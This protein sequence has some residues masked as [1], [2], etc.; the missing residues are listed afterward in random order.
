MGYNALTK[1]REK[2]FQMYGVKDSV[3]IPPL[4]KV[5]RAYGRDALAFVRDCCEDLLFDTGDE[6]RVALDDSDGR[7]AGP[8]RI[9]YNMERDIDRLCLEV[10]I[11]RFL[12]TGA[13]MDAFDIYYCYCEIFK[14]FGR[15]YDTTG[16]LLELLSEHET[17][18]SSLLMKHRDH[19]SHSVYVFLIGLAFYKNSAVI[20]KAYN[21]RY[22]LQ[23]GPEAARH[24]LKYWGMTALFHDIGYPF[25]IA[26]QQMKAYVCKIDPTNNDIYGFA[27]V[28]SY[29]RMDEF[30]VSRVG[31]LNKL[32]ARA[33]TERLDEH[34][35]GRVGEEAYFLR[36]KLVKTLKDRAVHYNPDAMDYL[37][38]DHAYFSGMILAKVY[39]NRHPQVKTYDDL[40]VALLDS[41]CAIILH[42]SLFKF[43]IRSI[44]HTAEPLS[45]N[46]GQP[47][48]YLLMLCDELQCWDRA[49]YGQNTRTGIY[50]FDF[51][52]T[53]NEGTPRFTYYYDEFCGDRVRRSKSY[54]LM[55]PD[56]YIKKSGARREHRCKF[57]DDIDEIVSLVD[58]ID[59]FEHDVNKPDE[60]ASLSVKI[61]FKSRRTGMYL[62]DSSYLN[63]YAFALSLN[64]R[65]CG[66]ETPEEMARAF[67]NDL[68]LEY[69]LS[70][71]AQAKNFGPQLET[72]RCFYTNRAVDYEPVSSFTI[73]ELGSLAESE[74]SRWCAEKLTMGWEYGCAHVGR[75]EGGA[76]DNVMRERT[77]LHHDLIGFFELTEE[78]IQK[79]AAP[80]AKMLELIREFDGL[81]IYRM[82]L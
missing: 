72:I 59:G 80:M 65:Y 26:H 45:L 27:P 20:R 76:N 29:R 64:G 3:H 47:L 57:L 19:Y 54:L 10:A 24:F 35:L 70:N 21:D 9:P 52:M 33:I 11:G 13:R 41:L 73:K 4:P 18:A 28:V 74:H 58:V 16:V 43:T 15:G 60:S 82:R 46:D 2:N 5:A 32:F 31:N 34:Y 49:S 55:Q 71:I 77:R 37:Y 62:S 79:D 50:P 1:M 8:G 12:N 22:G 66:A 6:R 17:N 7:S 42:N 48:S 30:A 51:D 81:T 53:F 61:M 44:I 39:L 40:P 63:L 78:E 23:E 67:E 68:S 38:M 56:G 69:K 25:E 14:P 36:H 75:L